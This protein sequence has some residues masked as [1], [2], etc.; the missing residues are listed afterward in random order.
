[1]LVVVVAVLGVPMAVVQV[2]DVV[3]VLD[4]LMA[5]VRAVLVVVL[6]VDIVRSSH[7]RILPL[8]FFI[9]TM[10]ILAYVYIC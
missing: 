9:L 5:A 10:H 2:V 6:S 8:G 3:A 7:T 1:M 4:G